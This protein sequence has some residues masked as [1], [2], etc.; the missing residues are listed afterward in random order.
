[1]GVA[2]KVV[3]GIGSGV[4]ATVIERGAVVPPPP[5]QVRV[6]VVAV[7]RVGVMKVPAV[8][9]APVQPPLAVQEV[10]FVLDHVRVA[11]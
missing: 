10:A 8:A 6:Y 11:V 3:V 9:F 1:M 7:V 4:T 2:V 5:V